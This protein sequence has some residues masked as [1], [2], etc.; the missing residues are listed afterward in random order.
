MCVHQPSF[1]VPHIRYCGR[2]RRHL[3]MKL[4]TVFAL[5]FPFVA[6]G[7]SIKRETSS[8]PYTPFHTSGRDIKNT[9]N[10][11]VTYAGVNWPGAADVMIPEGLQYQSVS[12][13]VSKIKSLGMNVIRLTYAIEMIDDIYAG[14]DVSLENALTIALGSENGTKVLNE[15][16]TAN[17]SF[18][19]NTTRLEVCIS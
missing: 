15:I 11:T 10:K 2:I 16:L 8:W 12:T 1:V 13:I 3:I 7:L 19:A 9:L 6:S 18:T 4:F 5:S 14:G 17:P